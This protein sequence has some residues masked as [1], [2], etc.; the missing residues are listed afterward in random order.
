[1]GS[2]F[3]PSAKILTFSILFP[4]LLFTKYNSK[5]CRLL[6]GSLFIYSTNVLISGTDSPKLF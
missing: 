1:M 4:I 5:L 2:Y 6:M 3:I